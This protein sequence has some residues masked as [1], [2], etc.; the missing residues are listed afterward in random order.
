MRAT[1]FALRVTDIADIVTV[2]NNQV[3]EII[4]REV[5]V[6]MLRKGWTMQ[7]LAGN[8]DLSP[9]TL[10]RYLRGDRDFP[11][12]TL[13]TTLRMLD[14]DFGDFAKHVDA[15]TAN[16]IDEIVRASGVTAESR[17]RQ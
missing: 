16:A 4:G 13:L 8:L 7:A 3:A 2:M 9:A 10:S 15:E 1:V 14:V 17:E 12:S 5:R 11:S 6:A